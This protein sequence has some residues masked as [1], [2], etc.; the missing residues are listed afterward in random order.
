MTISWKTIIEYRKLAEKILTEQGKIGPAIQG[1][2]CDSDFL[3]IVDLARALRISNEQAAHRTTQ[4][5][6]A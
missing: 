5:N 4:G 6:A 1:V 2:H 3:K